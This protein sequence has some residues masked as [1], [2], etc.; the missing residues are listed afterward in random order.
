MILCQPNNM[1]LLQAFDILA[2]LYVVTCLM[3]LASDMLRAWLADTTIDAGH[4]PLDA[5]DR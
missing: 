5:R 1:S 4:V 3:P 2:A